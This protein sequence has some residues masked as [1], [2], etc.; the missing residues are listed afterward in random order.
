MSFELLVS[1]LLLPCVLKTK[2]NTPRKEKNT[3]GATKSW[4]WNFSSDLDILTTTHLVRRSKRNDW[5][6]F[7]IQWQENHIHIY[8]PLFNSRSDQMIVILIPWKIIVVPISKT[9]LKP[10]EKI[11]WNTVV[12]NVIVTSTT[13]SQ[14]IVFCRCT[15]CSCLSTFLVESEVNFLSIFKIVTET[16]PFRV[17]STFE[18][19]KFYLHYANKNSCTALWNRKASSEN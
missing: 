16:P 13:R 1:A 4:H 19:S 15:T 14:A 10:V 7:I 9:K 17:I 2:E 6:Y 3:N 18:A 5:Y 12:C 11:I 8:H